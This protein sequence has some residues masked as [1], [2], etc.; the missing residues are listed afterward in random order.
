[1][2]KKPLRMFKKRKISKY[3][4]RMWEIQIL[5]VLVSLLNILQIWG[6]TNILSKMGHFFYFL[7]VSSDSIFSNF[8]NILFIL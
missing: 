4:V 5:E 7:K 3:Q 8:N 1:M 2:K 6:A